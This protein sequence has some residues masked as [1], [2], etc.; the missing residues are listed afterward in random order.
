[1][2]KSK[3]IL[4]TVLLVLAAVTAWVIWLDAG[5]TA[6]GQT[7][8]QQLHEIGRK[9]LTK[10][11]VQLTKD[12][13]AILRARP[14]TALIAAVIYGIVAALVLMVGKAPQVPQH[15]SQEEA[16]RL[17]DEMEEEY[18]RDDMLVFPSDTDEPEEDDDW[19]LTELEMP[20]LVSARWENGRVVFRWE[21]VEHA[22]AYS[23]WRRTGD[24]RWQRIGKT[25]EKTT[26]YLDFALDSDMTYYYSV[27]A[28]RIVDGQRIKSP[29][30]PLGLAV[31]VES[32][33]VLP[34]A[35]VFRDK[36]RE[37]NILVAWDPVPGTSL[38]RILR[39]EEG[40]DWDVLDRVP[41]K[42]E[43]RYRDDSAEPGVAFD[44]TVC[45]CV[46]IH[47]IPVVGHFDRNGITIRY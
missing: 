22:E 39:R 43:C 3:W 25:D 12:F 5:L 37:G 6:E 1:M 17:R 16:A 28:F 44:Y 2:K 29:R 36:D 19:A 30:D 15:V 46:L 9:N 33:N 26:L 10:E 41:A 45:A 21:P 31:H 40:E 27:R 14:V 18:L 20:K 11:T 23:V 13:K 35:R 32:G 24:T 4:V 8:L 7:V 34:A 42:G 38:Y 47:K